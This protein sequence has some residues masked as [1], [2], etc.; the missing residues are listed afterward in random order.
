MGPNTGSW[1]KFAQ[2]RLQI[3][4]HSDRGSENA[5]AVDTYVWIP[6]TF[7]SHLMD[8]TICVCLRWNFGNRTISSGSALLLSGDLVLL[9]PNES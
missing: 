4:T 3:L 6:L 8:E 1:A 7:F 2:Q 5:V 9:R